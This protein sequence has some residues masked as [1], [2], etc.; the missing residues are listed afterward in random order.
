MC[1]AAILR[2]H[3]PPLHPRVRSHLLL[4]QGL[5]V[6]QS[7]PKCPSSQ[8]AALP[9]PFAY[10]LA[11]DHLKPIFARREVAALVSSS[12]RAR[13]RRRTCPLLRVRGSLRPSR[14]SVCTQSLR[15]TLSDTESD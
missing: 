1:C 4:G 5:M 8:R 3:S 15:I 2:Y 7:H 6:L 9:G 11:L 12:A 10:L 14:L 13:C